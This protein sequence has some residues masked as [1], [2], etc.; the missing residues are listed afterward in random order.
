MF[1]WMWK[2]II[3][4]L[5]SVLYALLFVSKQLED[6]RESI[7]FKFSCFKYFAFERMATL[8]SH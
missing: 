4:V 8:G 2:Y 6:S 7:S 3:P 1:P 5:S